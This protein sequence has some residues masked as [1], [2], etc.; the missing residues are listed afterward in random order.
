M[1]ITEWQAQFIAAVQSRQY[2]IYPPAMIN[3]LLE[4]EADAV[5]FKAKVDRFFAPYETASVSSTPGSRNTDPLTPRGLWALADTIT[6][7]VV[8]PVVLTEEGA[9]VITEDQKAVQ[10]ENA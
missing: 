1:L 6:D 10:L 5:K 7:G 4:V 3:S 9:P 8:P 2:S